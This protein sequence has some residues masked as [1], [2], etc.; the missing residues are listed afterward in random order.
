MELITEY[1]EKKEDLQTILDFIFI[2]CGKDKATYDHII[3]WLSQLIQFP[4]IKTCCPFFISK[5]GAGK[6]TLISLLRTMLGSKKILETQNPNRDVWGDF[7]EEMEYAMIVI[8][9]ELTQKDFLDS[10][11]KY[12]GLATGGTLIINKK[13]KDKFEIP[14]FHRFI[15]TT[16]S[17]NFRPSRRTWIIRCSDELINDKEFFSKMLVLV[18]NIDVAK[19]FYEYLKAVEGADKFNELPIPSTEYQEDLKESNYSMVEKFLIHIA[20][21]N[22]DKIEYDILA[23]TLF[24]NFNSWIVSNKFKYEM[25]STA[26][27]LKL[28]QL[29]IDGVDKCE[30]RTNKGWNYKINIPKLNK[31]FKLGC[32]IK[33]ENVVVNDNLTIGADDDEDD[34]TDE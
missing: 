12:K 10:E 2:L 23:S 30:K 26:F 5:E 28:K 14:S 4:H 29:K 15:S 25:N 8:L 17:E 31:H 33:C 7:N 22:F 19:T 34:E 21:K 16:N 11:A 18:K 3:L 32:L 13:G 27:G 24:S 9:D 6:G 20:E 1:E